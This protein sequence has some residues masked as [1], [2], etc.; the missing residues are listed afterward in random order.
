MPRIDVD[1]EKLK[2]LS[3]EIKSGAEQCEQIARQL[4]RS[5]DRS[6]WHD[7]ERQK[8]EE[9]LKESLRALRR[10]SES[11]RSEF[12]AELQRKVAAL[13]QFRS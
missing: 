7:N 5:L 8:F 10:I 9:R 2:Q 12:P 13:E 1:P 3:K 11:F 4:Q 6:D